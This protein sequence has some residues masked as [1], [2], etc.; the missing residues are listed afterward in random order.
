MAYE[1]I[2]EDELKDLY[3]SHVAHMTPLFQPFDEFERIARNRPHPGIA[4]GLPRVTDG[5]LAAL[6]QEQP[7]RII[8]QIP[9]GKVKS[10]T[11]EWLE[12]VAGWIF[13]NEI[14]PNSNTQAALIQKCWAL[15]SKVLTYGAQPVFVQ[16]VN[17]GD[18][19]GTDFTLPYIKDVFLEPG[20]LSDKDSNCILVRAW[21]RPNDLDMIID[22]E[23]FLAKRAKERG[24]KYESTW[25]LDVLEA[26]KKQVKEKQ[27]EAQTAN[28]K[29]KNTKNEVI[30]LI[31]AFQRGIG[32][33]FYSFFPDLPDGE[34]VARR[35]KNKDPRGAIPIHYMYANVDL[36]NPLGRGSVELSGGM[37]NLLDSEVQSYQYMRALL[38]NPPLEIRG[39]VRSSI[40]KY[41]PAAQWKLG[42]DPNASVKPVDLSTSSLETFPNNYGLIKSQILNL[43]S[44][45]DTSISS[46]VGNPGFSKTPAGIDAQQSKLGVSDNYMRKQF[47]A[48][49]E[50][51]AETEIN[52]YFAERHGIQELQV[53]KETAERLRKIA[54][55]T[56]SDDNKIRIDFDTETEQLKF[57]VDASTSS[58][59]DDAAE[60]DRLI[61]LLDLSGKYPQLAE[62][63]GKDGA[64]ELINRIVIKSGVE[65]PEKIMPSEEEE[66]DEQGNP[67]PK[68]GDEEKV[69]PE[70]VQQMVM[71]GIEEAMASKG[72]DDIQKQLLAKFAELPEE[73]KNALLEQFGL[74]GGISPKQQELNIKKVDTAGKQ[75][76]PSDVELGV[77]DAA[78]DL[79]AASQEQA[80]AQAATEPV[81]PESSGVQAPEAPMPPE[82]VAPIEPEMPMIPEEDLE[83]VQIDGDQPEPMD[84][85]TPELDED[86]Q[87]L[88]MAL[89][90]RGYTTEQIAT[91]IAMLKD[92]ASDEE[93]LAA[94]MGE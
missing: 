10:E 93:V 87:M 42:T 45:T 80:A 55:D 37:Q 7:K 19:F 88:I 17:R 8:Q 38:M 11:N 4:K 15:T 2:K 14:L 50:D 26:A 76:G 59:K 47:E 1:Y 16:F 18:Y 21:F 66:V 9:T 31:H 12:I 34:N 89:Q 85:L 24:E 78:Q 61:E 40:I 41:A 35:K 60:R 54:P 46:E 77:Q 64:K 5:T 74:P 33:T 30:E 69:T 63:M 83:D 90:E 81:A 84:N 25:D 56:V 71:Q 75:A 52:L 73:S 32:A 39:N 65:D 51:V 29:D 43:N 92:G 20:K 53:D 91:A 79:T 70:M 62:L 44:S 6:I 13:E 58:L 49:F 28:E 22:K 57:E 68:Q 48:C 86:D 94:L 82:E 3:D 23:K 67:I 36:S 72:E 27:Q